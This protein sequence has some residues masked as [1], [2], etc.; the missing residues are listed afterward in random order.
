MLFFVR[1]LHFVRARAHLKSAPGDVTKR[2]VT[3]AS[4]WCWQQVAICCRSQN[5]FGCLDASVALFQVK[6][7]FWMKV[8]IVSYELK[9]RWQKQSSGC[10][11]LVHSLAQ[12][13]SWWMEIVTSLSSLCLSVSP[14]VFLLWALVANEANV[15][16]GILREVLD[17][18]DLWPFLHLE[19][20]TPSSGGRGR[21]DSF[22]GCTAALVFRL[23]CPGGFGSLVC[24]FGFFC[25]HFHFSLSLSLC[26]QPFQ[27]SSS[28]RHVP[29]SITKKKM[30][31]N[32]PAVLNRI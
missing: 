15:G 17:P 20:S 26:K 7:L 13:C 11:S 25:F 18:G 16:V 4:S 23:Q 27:F 12:F 21:A 19:S 9:L 10:R 2:T 24:S 5:S 1:L 6:S 3:F 32:S 30:H 8:Y 29:P 22:L 28:V 14:V 31:K